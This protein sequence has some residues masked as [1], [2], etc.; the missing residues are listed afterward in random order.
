[1]EENVASDVLQDALIIS[2]DNIIDYWVFNSVDSFMPH[3]IGKK[4]NIMFKVILDRFI[5]V[6]MNHEKLLEWVRYR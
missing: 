1:M 6:I 3:P 4:F 2:L 5:F